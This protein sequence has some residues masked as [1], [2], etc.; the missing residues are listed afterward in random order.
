M[1]DFQIKEIRNLLVAYA[2]G[3]YHKQGKIS[4]QRDE[5]DMIISGINLLGE[6]LLATTVS[7]DYFNSIYSSVA[8]MVFVVS[9]KGVIEDTN[10]A[11]GNI[12]HFNT[13]DLIGNPLNSI[14]EPGG[15]SFF[16][17]IKKNLSSGEKSC[18]CEGRF[19]SSD[20]T[21]IPVSCSCSKIIDKNN[22]FK[23]YLIIAED[24]TERKETEKLILRTIV[25]TQEKEQK[26][27]SLDLHD[28]LGSELSTVKLLLSAISESLSSSN[29]K[30]K[31]AY[32]TCKSLID[33]SIVSLRAIC[34]DLM[35]ASLEKG[36]INMALKE[37]MDRLGKQSLI[38]F[39]YNCPDSL[40]E[41]EKSLEIVIYR[42]AQ[43]SMAN[44][45]KHA[46]ATKI[47]MNL[48]CDSNVII[49]V[50][51]DNGRGFKVSNNKLK[52]GRGLSNMSSRVKAFN[53]TF[54]LTSKMNQG[55]KLLITFPID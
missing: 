41:L 9:A 34:F 15:K 14:A 54:Q 26:R 33:S 36:G 13:T 29:N 50:I 5:I 48:S 40:P 51:R 35:P 27:F 20:N 11:A 47:D 1:T 37:L 3:E 49:F 19:V 39:N 42:I 44:V 16:N 55:T 17:G 31:E 25:D 43:E 52:R 38:N 46:K 12:L 24:I 23:G 10:S 7:R 53:G 4:E 2:A 18:N 8:D 32:E 21:L 22:K 28:G 30:Y 6:E 45:I